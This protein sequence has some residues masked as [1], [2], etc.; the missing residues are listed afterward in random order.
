L[1]WWCLG[2]N[3]RSWLLGIEEVFK[4]WVEGLG[5]VFVVAGILASSPEPGH[6]DGCLDLVWYRDT[7]PLPP[8]LQHYVPSAPNS[9]LT[10]SEPVVWK[11]WRSSVPSPGRSGSARLCRGLEPTKKIDTEIRDTTARRGLPDATSQ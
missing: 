1:W 11:N 7:H 3:V 4:G 2:G 9:L 8:L 5:W 10:L 6:G